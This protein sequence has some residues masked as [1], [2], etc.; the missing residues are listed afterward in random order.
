MTLPLRAAFEPFPTHLNVKEL[1][2]TTDNFEFA[3]RIP[4]EALDAYPREEFEKLVHLNVIMLGI[5]LVIEGFQAHL[6][7]RLFSSK[8][9]QR[10]GQSKSLPC[11]H[12]P[13]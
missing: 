9:L 3:A 8:W 11:I 4:T 1:V 2:D 6:D 10:N 12:F 13:I 7:K 5:P